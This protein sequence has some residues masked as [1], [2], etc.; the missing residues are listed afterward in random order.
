VKATGKHG[1]AMCGRRTVGRRLRSVPRSVPR[2]YRTRAGRRP[3]KC[4][5]EGDV[6]TEASCPAT[7]KPD[8]HPQAS[9]VLPRTP[10]PRARG[11]K[12]PR[13]QAPMRCRHY[14]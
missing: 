1:T 13:L 7:S 4:S 5:H 2:W 9:S 6:V 10:H 12:R 8:L 14:E 3:S 11:P